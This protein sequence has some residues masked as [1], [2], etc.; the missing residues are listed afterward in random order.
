MGPRTNEAQ[1]MIQALRNIP[2]PNGTLIGGVAA[3]YTDTQGGIA[4]TLPWAFGWIALG[5]LVLLFLFTGSI[6]L[7]IK[8]VI[9]NVL[10]LAAMMGALTW[11]FIEG[12]M[13]WLVGSFTNTH[14][15]D[16]SM[17][18][19]VSVVTFGL[20]MD[21][22]V[23]LLSRIKEEHESGMKNEDAVATGLQRSARIITAAALIMICVFFSFAFGGER[24]IAEF[25]IGLGGAVLIDAFIIRTVLV[26]SLM[27]YFGKANWWMP[28][29]LDKVI[30]NVAL[31]AG[32]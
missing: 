31:E 4:T 30:P 29:W 7:P 20:S 17:V 27:H 32:E 12:H 15:I 9:L 10:S 28:K 14:T 2:A 3:D 11:I 5:V 19:L 22:E 21:Y 1:K 8:A 25:G 18:I 13:T 26:P 23:F 16:T 6:V 24:I